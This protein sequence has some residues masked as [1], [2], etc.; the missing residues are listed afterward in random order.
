METQNKLI[1]QSVRNLMFSVNFNEMEDMINDYKDF[2]TQDPNHKPF[3]KNF[4][5]YIGVF[6]TIIA[7]I[8]TI[9]IG[10]IIAKIYS[11]NI[12]IRLILLFAIGL[13]IPISI[14]NIF[15]KKITI[16]SRYYPIKEGENKKSFII[17]F[18]PLT[19]AILH[20]SFNLFFCFESWYSAYQ[21]AHKSEVLA[22]V[23][24]II[25]VVYSFF[26]FVFCSN[27]YFKFFS[28]SFISMMTVFQ[29]KAISST[30]SSVDEFNFYFV[31]VILLLI[32]G[33]ISAFI[34]N[35]NIRKG[36]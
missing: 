21:I 1:L 33:T 26:K 8:T 16:L 29:F 18:I 10:N 9:S 5:Y 27:I 11:L 25:F 7:L 2:L 15:N 12:I 28:T 30:L 14:Y 36:E 6:I 3:E 13:L 24:T 32:S 34:F 31:F 19:I 20:F 22:S 35:K 17:S 4:K 23:L